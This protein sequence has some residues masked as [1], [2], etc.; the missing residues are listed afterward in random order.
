VADFG[1]AKALRA[2][3]E[4]QLTETGLAV[5]TPAY[6]SPEQASGGQVDGRSDIYALGCVVYEMLA[7]EPPFAGSTPQAVIAKRMLE[8]VPHVRTLRDT[9]SVPMEQALLRALAKTPADRFATAGEFT[10]ALSTL[11]MAATATGSADPIVS[12]RAV[13]RHWWVP[14]GLVAV[15]LLGLGLLFAWRKGHRLDEVGEVGPTRLAVLPFENLSRPEDQYFADGVTDEVRGKLTA[16]PGL[17]V[18]ARASSAEYKHTSKN[19]QQIGRELSVDYLLTGTVRWEKTTGGPSRVRVSPELVKVSTASTKWQAPFEAPLTD[20]FQVQADVAA[21]VAEALGLAL[22]AGER[23]RLAERPTQSLAAYDAFL[24][25]EEALRGVADLTA[26]R[27]ALDYYQ[28]AVALDSTF[29]LA[30]AQLSLVQSR[31]NCGTPTPA[32]AAAA[33][34][35]ADRARA[36]VPSLPEIYFA[37]AFY[38]WCVRQDV[39]QALEQSRRASELAPNNALFLTVFAQNELA[40][41]QTEKGLEHLRKAQILDPRSVET[42]ARSVYALIGLRRYSEAMQA[43]D[44]GLALAPA[45][46]LLIHGKVEAHVAQGDLAGARAVLQAVPR[47]VDPAALVAFIATVDDLYWV[48]DDTQQRLLL[49]LSPSPFGDDRASWAFALAATYALRGDT[50]QSRAYADSVR[51]VLEGRLRE[52]PEDA[53]TRGWLAKAL[54]YMGRNADAIRDGKRALALVPIGMGPVVR[55]ELQVQLARTYVLV[56]ELEKALDQLESVPREH[57]LSPGWLKIDPTF[58]PLRGKPRFERLIRSP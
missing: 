26:Y 1:I 4:V 47:D 52:R 3:G 8:P 10:R 27:R 41:G 24:K 17:E 16:L 19:P 35:A 2:A 20:V 56:G 51:L 25:G 12:G 49:R 11:T 6:M 15:I 31:V 21:R 22:G 39:A 46:L 42:A 53:G 40:L 48:L 5:G 9:V 29:A 45:N 28:R 18:I 44:R 14:A 57:F 54:A 34:K 38:H 33:L 13:R 50:T 23:Q 43:A 36:L 37:L 55:G 7:G 30:W 32:G 58:A